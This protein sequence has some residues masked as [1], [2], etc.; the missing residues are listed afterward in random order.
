MDANIIADVKFDKKAGKF[1]ISGPS[2]NVLA[3]ID[4]I[5][6]KMRQIMR[7]ENNRSSAEVLF[8]QIQ[9]H[10]LKEDQT[11]TDSKEIPYDMKPNYVI[12]CAYK[13]GKQNVELMASGG[14]MYVIDFQKLEEYPKH[15]ISDTVKVIRKDI[16]KGNLIL[17]IIIY[18]LVG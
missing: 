10:W 11:A 7:E 14:R 9:W 15:N 5:H 8:N 17:F 16:L 4:C 13:E 12:E 3:A 18:Y 6:N 2:R 1:T